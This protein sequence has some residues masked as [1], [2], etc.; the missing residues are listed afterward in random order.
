MRRVA[1]VALLLVAGPA[2]AAP[3]AAPK[4]PP[5]PPAPA[6]PAPPAVSEATRACLDCHSELTP[7]IVA[8]WRGSL[9]AVTTVDA[10]L[11]K[12]AASRRVSV[13][14]AP[15]GLGAVVVGCAE[16]HGLRA[17][18][19]P[20]AFDHEGRRVHTVVSP[21]DCATC[22]PVEN[23]QFDENL[24]ARANGNL[25][26]NPL[27]R[28]LADQSIGPL[29]FDGA[30]LSHALPT[31]DARADACLSC[32]GTVVSVEGTVTRSTD[33]GDMTFPVLRNWPNQGVG[34]INPD[35]SRGACSACHTR[36]RFSIEESRKA[37]SCATCHKGPDVPAYAVWQVS[38][39][40]VLTKALGA[41]WN[42]TAVPWTAGKDYSAPTCAACHVSGVVT[43]GGTV[44][45]ARSHRMNDRLATRLFGLPYAHPHPA[46][47]DTAQLRTAD[48]LPLPTALDGTPS[49]GLIDA[50]EQGRREAALKKVCSPCHSQGWVDGHF[51][52]LHATVD[53]TNAQTKAATL[54][55]QQAW[56][57]GLASGPGRG[58]LF[59]EG[60][61]RSWVEQWLFYANSTRFAAAM[62][63]ADYGTFANG[64]WWLTKNLRQMQEWLKDRLLL[65]AR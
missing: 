22:H 24:M 50:A 20:D 56:K 8:D 39:H 19:H 16:C 55:V 65:P 36:H 29:S 32:H 12:P 7:G 21:P 47:V 13:A 35:G 30:S 2:A 1:L 52:R 26:A 4:A 63:G 14:A 9:H 37:E 49:A 31:D 11:A 34:R 25:M 64:R 44:V 48:G 17:A 33:M 61:E 51:R 40:G 18:D 23:E 59:D 15:V 5:P 54:I 3:K 27:F 45:S 60:I 53:E 58:S 43:D 28:D 6:S 38:K 10:A 46:E 41:K 42:W 62:A 57:E